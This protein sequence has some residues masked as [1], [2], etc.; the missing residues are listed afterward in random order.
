M[1]WYFT[2]SVS[3]SEIS[4]DKLGAVVMFTGEEALKV[5]EFCIDPNSLVSTIKFKSDMNQ[6]ANRFYIAE[7]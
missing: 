4:F 6:N 1:S 7:D 5:L 3:S 2:C